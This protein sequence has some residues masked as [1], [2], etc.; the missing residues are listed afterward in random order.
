MTAFAAPSRN[1]QKP[2]DNTLSG[3]KVFIHIQCENLVFTSFVEVRHSATDELTNLLLVLDV[4]LC[5]ILY[6]HA[7]CD[8]EKATI[9]MQTKK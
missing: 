4:A 1:T 6:K 5:N 8:I 2:E 9:V 7:K 3:Y